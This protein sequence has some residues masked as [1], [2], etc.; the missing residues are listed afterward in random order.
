MFKSYLTRRKLNKLWRKQ[1]PH[2]STTISIFDNNKKSLENVK[3]G[4]CTYGNIEPFI[5]NHDYHLVIGSF[6]SIAPNV[7]FVL[8]G[9][10]ALNHLTTFPFYSKCVDGRNEAISKGDIILG[11]DVWVGV[12]SIILSNV[13]IG[14]GAVIA[15]GSVV[16][17][18][19]PPY[20]IVGGNP[21]RIIKHRFS[22]KVIKK[23]LELDLSKLEKES[24]NNNLDSLYKE[25]NDENVDEVLKA[26]SALKREK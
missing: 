14:Q 23:L 17:K 6:C 7:S 1:N 10:H 3:V 12:G 2:N 8:S 16:T 5:F 25:I 24:I 15:A 11:D 9:D 21:A 26:F 20:A 4:K 13:K 18:D 19:I 22:D